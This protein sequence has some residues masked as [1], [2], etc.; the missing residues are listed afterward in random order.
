MKQEEDEDSQEQITDQPY[1]W[2]QLASQ[3]DVHGQQNQ[4]SWMSNHNLDHKVV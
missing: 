4:R 1:A 2:S 3:L